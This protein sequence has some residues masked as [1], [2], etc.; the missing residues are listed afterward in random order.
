MDSLNP[1][2]FIKKVELGFGSLKCVAKLNITFD[3]ALKNVKDGSS[4][5]HSSNENNT[6][7]E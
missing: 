6:L 5:Y 7:I 2:L 4:P 1:L 3:F